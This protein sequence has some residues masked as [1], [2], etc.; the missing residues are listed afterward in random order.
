MTQVVSITKA[1]N[2][3]SELVNQV[4]YQGRQFLVKKMDKP[5]AVLI[6]IED[7]KDLV[8]EAEMAREKRF[9]ELFAIA[10]KNKDIPFSQ[11][12]KD[13]ADAIKKVRG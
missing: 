13:V 6:K 10:E 5:M 9:K 1:R 7:L 4:Y 11:V 2:N 3:L 12:K 8:E